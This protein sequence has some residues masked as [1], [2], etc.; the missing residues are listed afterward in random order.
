[1]PEPGTEEY[2]MLARE[3]EKVF[4]HTIT[5]QVQ[6]IIGISLLEILSKHSSDEIYL[7]Q[8]DTPEWTS[9]AKALEAFKRFGT[10]LEGIES[11]VPLTTM[12]MP[13]GSRPGASPTASP[14]DEIF[15][16]RSLLASMRKCWGACF[17]GHWLNNLSYA[18]AHLTSK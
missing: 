13:P 5:N 6:A 2:A 11:E 7:G 18:R 3:P 15:G 12:A 16:E 9:D 8:R 17:Q 14:F 10:R 1:M 4:I